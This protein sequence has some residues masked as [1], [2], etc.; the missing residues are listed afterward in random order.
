[1]LEKIELKAMEHVLWILAILVRY[2]RLFGE[3]A[4]VLSTGEV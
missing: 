4:F 3:V 2:M 1:M